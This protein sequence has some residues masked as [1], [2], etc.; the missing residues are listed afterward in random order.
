MRLLEKL[1]FKKK[2]QEPD[3]TDAAMVEPDSDDTTAEGQSANHIEKQEEGHFS[4]SDTV[5]TD[6][7]DTVWI[8][9]EQAAKIISGD[10][11]L[12]ENILLSKPAVSSPS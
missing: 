3:H 10:Q 9:P 7:A 12:D 1:G 11:P 5:R 4:A 6:T 8:S 2:I